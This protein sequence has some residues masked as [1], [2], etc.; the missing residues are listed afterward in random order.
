MATSAVLIGTELR[1][2]PCQGDSTTPPAILSVQLTSRIFQTLHVQLASAETVDV[3][4]LGSGRAYRLNTRPVALS[5]LAEAVEV[6]LDWSGQDEW[7]AVDI[8]LDM[9]VDDGDPAGPFT[10]T[11]HVGELRFTAAA[12]TAVAVVALES[13][14][15]VATANNNR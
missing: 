13:L 2:T 5:S 3:S 14:Q 4:D 6:R 7:P 11:R 12:C 1:I 8:D 9:I 15:R 10:V